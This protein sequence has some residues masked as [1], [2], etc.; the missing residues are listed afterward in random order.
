MRLWGRVVLWILLAILIFQIALAG[1]CLLTAKRDAGP[2]YLGD[3]FTYAFCGGQI[4]LFGWLG[5]FV[6]KQLTKRNGGKK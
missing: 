1:N 5:W 4:L 6:V 3:T 2:Y